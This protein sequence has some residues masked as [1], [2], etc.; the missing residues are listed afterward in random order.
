MSK[1][2]ALY[3]RVSTQKQLER[4]ESIPFQKKLLEVEARKKGWAFR[5]YSDGALTG[6]NTN[7]SQFIKMLSDVEEGFINAVIF[8]DFSRSARDLLDQLL[9]RRTLEEKNIE[10]ISLVERLDLSTDE[11]DFMFKM[12]ALVNE[13]YR[14]DA[15]KRV[16]AK[17][18][19]M[20]KQGRFTGGQPPY[21][22]IVKNKKLVIE[23]KEASLV[24]IIY[25]KFEELISY[26]GVT[27]WLNNLG[28]LT[29]RKKPWAAAT[30]K[31][32]LENPVY[33]GY[34]TYGKRAGGSKCT[35]P[36]DKWITEKIKDFEPVLTEEYFDK[37]QRIIR[38]R[39]FTLP[40]RKNDYLLSGL[41]FCGECSSGM[42][43]ATLPKDKYNKIYR[44][45]ACN[46]N[47][48]KGKQFC[49]MQRV[50]LPDIEERVLQEVKNIA[51][52]HFEQS[53]IN[54]ILQKK[55]ENLKDVQLRELK[56]KHS[57]LMKGR[58]R[59]IMLYQEGKI[60]NTT[61]ISEKINKL[62]LEMESVTMQIDGLS[63]EINPKSK[64]KRINALERVNEMNEDIFSLPFETKRE[65]L[66]QLIKKITIFRA[67][68]IEI[69][70]YDL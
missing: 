34:Q 14:K 68:G 1:I 4:G 52:I 58:D 53:E 29:K 44:Y 35:L 37:I 33:K 7:R 21:G 66:R 5:H 51:R 48:H 49:S 10:I 16:R 25:S 64:K 28:Y 12:Q 32:I 67:K 59:L 61:V 2:C 40:K 39:N 43:G 60:K 9:L 6:G 47:I 69:E 20:A 56:N 41:L 63:A 42:C 31:R 62:S 3:S 70:H 15:I 24:K 65:I 19:D 55:K 17:M 30:V 45:Y 50:R 23:Q 38:G 13:R 46:T 54:N 27:N 18:W 11:G 57:D 22:Y 26:R 8:Y 36:K